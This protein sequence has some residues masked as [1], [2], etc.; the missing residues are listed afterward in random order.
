VD[1]SLKNLLLLLPMKELPSATKR[2]PTILKRCFSLMSTSSPNSP[3]FLAALKCLAIIIDRCGSF[4]KLDQQNLRLLVQTANAHLEQLQHQVATFALLAAIIKHKLVVPELYDLIDKLCK[5]L[6]TAE[7]ASVR[8]QCSKLVSRFLVHYPIGDKRLQQHIDF[9]IR[10][11]AYEHVGGREALLDLVYRM[12]NRFPN[13]V[14]NARLELLFV[15]LV[16]R[17]VNDDSQSCRSMVAEILKLLMIAA[18]ASHFASIYTMATRW[19]ADNTNGTLQRVAAQLFSLF[20]EVVLSTMPTGTNGIEVLK[21]ISNRLPALIKLLETHLA[22]PFE[23]DETNSNEQNASDLQSDSRAR[24]EW[25]IKYY[26]LV[27]IEKLL[28]EQRV[29]ITVS[30]FKVCLQRVNLT[31][32]Q[33]HNHTI[34]QSHNH[35]ITITVWCP[36]GVA[37]LT[38]KYLQFVANLA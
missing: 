28:T 18:N 3:V 34:T 25:Q 23:I 8:I 9:I 26:S 13:E 22:V 2:G 19:Y 15:P 24:S 31:I 16:L 27:C 4:I 20:I 32:S 35:T 5:L 37:R 38:C 7:H 21:S 33:S 12:V 17:L 10:N 14:I 30:Q 29:L 11:L 6:L 36:I 1:L